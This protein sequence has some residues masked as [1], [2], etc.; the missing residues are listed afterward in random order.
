MTDPAATTNAAP[1]PIESSI[2]PLITI[3]TTG[4]RIFGLSGTELIEGRMVGGRISEVRRLNIA[5]SPAPGR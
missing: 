3:L 4:G 5:L 1:P 2:T